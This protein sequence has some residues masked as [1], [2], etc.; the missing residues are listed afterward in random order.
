MFEETKGEEVTEE[1]AEN[2]DKRGSSG[3]GAERV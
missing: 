2:G 1:D 3:T